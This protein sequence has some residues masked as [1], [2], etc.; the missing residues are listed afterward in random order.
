MLVCENGELRIG[1]LGTELGMKEALYRRKSDDLFRKIKGTWSI[2]KY[3]P[4]KDQYK[5][6]LQN[7]VDSI[8]GHESLICDGCEGRNSLLIS[9]A[10]YLSSW[11]RAM[12]RLPKEGS[13][14]EKLFEQSFE[15][16]LHNLTNFLF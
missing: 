7:F 10:A 12:A 5:V 2:E 3:E 9:N 1:E 14:E 8:N 4:E 6:M 13:P 11:T 16:H 15:E